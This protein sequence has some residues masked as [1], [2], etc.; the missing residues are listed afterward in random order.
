[1][2]QT[3]RGRGSLDGPPTKLVRIRSVKEL[4]QLLE[5]PVSERLQLVEAIWD[6]LTEVPEAVPITDDVKEELDRRLA[7]YYADPS[8]ARPWSEIREELFGSK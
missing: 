8:S 7:A 6:S 4:S 5:L 3:P 2:V 1:V